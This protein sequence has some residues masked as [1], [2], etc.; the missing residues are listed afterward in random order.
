MKEHLKKMHMKEA[1]HHKKMHAHHTR[2]AAEHHGMMEHHHEMADEAEN[3]DDNNPSG[4]E[5]AETPVGRSF[6][7][8]AR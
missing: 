8:I 4:I 6:G 1:E 5:Q 7:H 3:E 2:M